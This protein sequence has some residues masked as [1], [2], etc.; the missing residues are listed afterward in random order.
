MERLTQVIASWPVGRA[1]RIRP[2]PATN[3]ASKRANAKWAGGADLLLRHC[4]AEQEPDD[5][6]NDDASKIDRYA[7]RGWRLIC[8]MRLTIRRTQSRYQWASQNRQGNTCQRTA[9]GFHQI[10]RSNETERDGKHG[11]KC[12][13][14]QSQEDRFDNLI[15]GDPVAVSVKRGVPTFPPHRRTDELHISLARSGSSSVDSESVRTRRSA[16]YIVRARRTGLDGSL[17]GTKRTGPVAF[18]KKLNPSTVTV[19]SGF[20]AGRRDHKI[21]S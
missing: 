9:H 20:R 10:A 18:G 3:S 11:A 6:R 17:P 15:P 21:W 4:P 19:C 13:R 8:P 2:V 1:R 16:R 5:R 14:Q 7:G 12:G